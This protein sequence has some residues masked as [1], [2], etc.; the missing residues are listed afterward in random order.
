[1]WSIKHTRHISFVA[2]ILFLLVFCGGITRSVYPQQQ[3]SEPDLGISLYPRSTYLE[4]PTE[5]LQKDKGVTWI[6]AGIYHT[7]DPIKEVIGYFKNQAQQFKPPKDKSPILESLLRDNWKVKKT[8][9]RYVSPVF[10]IDHN[11]VFR[12]DTGTTDPPFTKREPTLPIIS[13][14]AENSFGLLVH[15]QSSFDD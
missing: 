5:K 13:V 2:S 11:S 3:S 10:V 15:R 9:I 1:M 14:E 7:D 4:K 6:A 8:D 12:I